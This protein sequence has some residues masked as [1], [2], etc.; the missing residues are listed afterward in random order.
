M[1]RV[2]LNDVNQGRYLVSDADNYE[3]IDGGNIGSFFK[4]LGR[5]FKKVGSEAVHDVGS[6]G[7]S[8]AK[9]IAKT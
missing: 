7:K 6:V 4:H 9:D 3:E 1:V 2:P 5:S 8:V